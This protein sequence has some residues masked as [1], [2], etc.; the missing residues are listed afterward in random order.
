MGVGGARVVGQAQQRPHCA[1]LAPGLVGYQ[2]RVVAL[3]APTTSPCIGAH[4][5][6]HALQIRAR[7][8]RGIRL[9]S[10]QSVPQLLLCSRARLAQQISGSKQKKV[11]V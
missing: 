9:G 11:A 6:L 8:G 4:D 1:V 10:L 5:T 3:P 7:S 2:G